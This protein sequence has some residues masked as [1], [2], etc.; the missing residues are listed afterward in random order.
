MRKKDA[1]NLSNFEASYSEAIRLRN[2]EAGI[3]PMIAAATLYM[4]L[5]DE[6]TNEVREIMSSCHENKL[7][8]LDEITI[9]GG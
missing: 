6:Y 4:L 9:F 1:N 3:Q 5:V 2:T 7:Y 8:K